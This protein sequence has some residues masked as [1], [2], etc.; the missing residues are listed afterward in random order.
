MALTLDRLPPGATLRNDALKGK[1]VRVEGEVG[2]G[3][4]LTVIVRND[5]YD[6]WSFDEKLRDKLRDQWKAGD[7]IRFYG[8]LGQ[9]KGRWQFIIRDETWVK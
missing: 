8:E 3:S 5:V 4:R 7:S 6:I 9:Y 2:R 1:I